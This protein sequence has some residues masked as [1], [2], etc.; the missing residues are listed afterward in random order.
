MSVASKFLKN[1]GQSMVEPIVTAVSPLLNDEVDELADAS[2]AKL[3]E[4]VADTSTT[5]DNLILLKVA[6][7]ARR[8]ADGVLGSE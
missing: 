5:I 3:N 2:V 4:M 6:R 8:F 7:F 1:L